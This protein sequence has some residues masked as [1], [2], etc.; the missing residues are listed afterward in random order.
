VAQ[1]DD[2]DASATPACPLCGT[3]LREVEGG[4]ECAWDGTRIDVPWVERPTHG[5][6]LP[7]IH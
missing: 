1:H 2:F 5:D 3:V 6:D 4:Y 7:S